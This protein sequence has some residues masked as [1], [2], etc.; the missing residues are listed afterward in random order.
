M[1]KYKQKPFSVCSKMNCN[2]LQIC[3]LYPCTQTPKCS[4]CSLSPVSS[5]GPSKAALLCPNAKIKLPLNTL[6]L[7]LLF[8]V[9]YAPCH[10]AGSDVLTCLSLPTSQIKQ[11]QG[12]ISV[13]FSVHGKPLSASPF[14]LLL[15]K[16][17]QKFKFCHFLKWS[18]LSK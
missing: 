5:T 17:V 18:S 6:S 16:L 13:C 2:F 8:T 3:M 14:T 11:I 4:S 10:A 7:F 9:L 1:L 15:F 12:L